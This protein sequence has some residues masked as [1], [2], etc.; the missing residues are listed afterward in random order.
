KKGAFTGANKDKAGLLDKADRGCLFLDEIGEIEAG[1]QVK[2]LRA[3]E[4]GGFT[5]VGCSELHQPDLRIIAATNRNLTEMVKAGKMRSD[6]FYRVHVI[7]IHLPPLRERKEDIPLLTDYCLKAYD[8]KIR[9]RITAKIMDTLMN[10]TWPGNVRELQNVL[11]RF[12]TLKRLDLTGT[13]PSFDITPGE[14]TE[15]DEAPLTTSLGDAVAAFEK[16]RINAALAECR[17]NRTHTAKHL[18]IGLRTLQRKMKQY[19]I[20]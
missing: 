6:F 16:Q 5:P 15:A 3:I 1:F 12:V 11:Y 4:G 7:P 8:R 17:W 2:L 9:P 14:G 13:V 10:Y 20:Q 19:G 18:R